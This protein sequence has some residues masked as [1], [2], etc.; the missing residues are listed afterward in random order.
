MLMITCP[1]C[2]AV[3]EET[4]FHCGGEAHIQRRA[5]AGDGDA[6]LA[7]YLFDRGNP[8]GV[9]YER[10]RHVY[11]CGKWFHLAR[12]SRT[13]E[14]YASYDIKAPEPPEEVRAAV[15]KALRARRLPAKARL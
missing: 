2:G 4:D 9:S 12:D 13:M 6:D 8:K 14:I 11:G 7:A 3:G 5:G 10:W 15:D 1:V